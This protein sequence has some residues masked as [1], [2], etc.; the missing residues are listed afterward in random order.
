MRPLAA[1][2]P[3]RAGLRAGGPRRRL[4]QRQESQQRVGAHGRVGANPVAGGAAHGHPVPALDVRDGPRGH[5]AHAALEARRPV[6]GRGG[7][8]V[9]RVQRKLH[10][11][12]RF[13]GPLA[14][15]HL[16]G[17]GALSPVDVP[18]IVTVAHR[19]HAHDLVARAAPQRTLTAQPSTRLIG[20]QAHRVHRRVDD[21][22]TLCAELARLLEQPEGEPSGDAKPDMAVPT[23]PGWRPAIGG[24][25][26]RPRAYFQEEAALVGGLARAQIFDLDGVRRHPLLVVVDLDFH[27]VR[28][29]HLGARRQAPNHGQVSKR[30][31]THHARHHDQREQHAQQQIEQ[32]VAGVDGGEADAEGDA[33]EVL[34]FSRE[35]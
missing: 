13:A 33:D 12:A 7:P 1:W 34:S 15:H 20:R 10:V 28:A 18:W 19:T 30:Q 5:V 16:R 25:L 29:A 22:V 4:E 9:G 3:R 23:A 35:A 17:H 2:R 21:Q 6:L 11:A 8:G 26:R 24:D 32:V 14:Q 27:Q 31:L